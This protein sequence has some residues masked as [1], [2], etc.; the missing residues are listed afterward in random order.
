[1]DE[2]EQKIVDA[3]IAVI[4]RYGV[5]RTTMND[6]ASEAGVVRQTLYNVYANKDEVLRATIRLHADRSLAIIEEACGQA[7][8]LDDQLNIVFTHLAVK[9]YD[10]VHATPHADEIIEGF[11]TA[12]KEE[13][14]V[15]EDRYRS[16]V[17]VLLAPHAKAIGKAGL[18]VTELADFT[19]TAFTGFKK[20]AKSR[21]HLV[22]LLA[23]LKT[24]VLTVTG[25]G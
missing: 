4:S 9:P 12:A 24:M 17:E 11:N 16:A 10:M 18:G 19:V 15:A 3:A 25:S 6:I 14:V 23:S 1:M 21:K 8:D 13:L 2:R 7:T 20:R 22:G 5:K